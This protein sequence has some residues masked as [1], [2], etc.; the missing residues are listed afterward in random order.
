MPR[1]TAIKPQV[2]RTDRYSIFIDEKY[3]FPLSANQ[4]LNEGVRVGQELSDEDLTELQQRAALGKGYDQALNLIAR[5]P[6][7]E[8]ELRDYLKAKGYQL[9]SCEEI[10]NMLSEKGYVNDQDFAARWVANRRLLKA[11][12][13]RKLVQELKQKGLQDDVI[14]AAL[15]TDKTNEVQVL[16][17]LILKKRN[18]SRYKDTVKLMQYLSRQGFNY[19]D[20]KAALDAVENR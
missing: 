14:Q 4:L 12:S 13:R 11:T 6:R 3:S 10:L 20:I 2:K 9:T 1:I 7:S 17:D 18:Q 5:R 8:R 19:E 15:Q 16:K